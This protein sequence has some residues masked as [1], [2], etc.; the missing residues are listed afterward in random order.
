MSCVFTVEKSS[1]LVSFCL[2]LGL[3]KG[4]VLF[5][6]ICLISMLG[7][8]QLFQQIFAIDVNAQAN[9]TSFQTSNSFQ[10]DPPDSSQITQLYDSSLNFYSQFI[11]CINRSFLIDSQFVPFQIALFIDRTIIYRT[12]DMSYILHFFCSLPFFLRQI[13]TSCQLQPFLSYFLSAIS[14]QYSLLVFSCTFS[15][16]YLITLVF[17]L[18]IKIYLEIFQLSQ[19]VR[20]R[21]KIH[22]QIDLKLAVVHEDYKK[23]QLS[24][25]QLAIQGGR[26][27]KTVLFKT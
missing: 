22:D 21:K 16:L 11:P 6:F 18:C 24:D 5:V 23:K 1:H 27:V 7:L 3:K 26:A 8:L 15:L 25:I 17:F 2:E 10:W 20:R 12:K 4:S 14:P 9:K 13:Y 19:S